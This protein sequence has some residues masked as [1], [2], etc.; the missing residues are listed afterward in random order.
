M[1]VS[2]WVLPPLQALREARHAP[3]GTLLTN[4]AALGGLGRKGLLQCSPPARSKPRDDRNARARDLHARRRLPRREA[5]RAEVYAVAGGAA[6]S[7]R[8]NSTLIKALARAF[9]WKRMLE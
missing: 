5:R 1:L 4:V 3:A 6:Q 2:L 9:R 8:T 7:H